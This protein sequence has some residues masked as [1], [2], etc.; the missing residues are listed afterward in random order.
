MIKHTGEDKDNSPFLRP[1]FPCHTVPLQ[2]CSTFAS[3]N[4][5]CLTNS[6]T[7]SSL[8][9]CFCCF[10]VFSSS[11]YLV[12]SCFWGFSLSL[13]LLVLHCWFL[14]LF[15]F[16]LFFFLIFFFLGGGG[17]LGIGSFPSSFFVFVFVL[18][19]SCMQTYDF[20]CFIFSLSSFFSLVVIH[21]SSSLVRLWVCVCVWG[22][23]VPGSLPIR[24]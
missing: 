14:F 19:L 22:G 21:R 18:N 7:V 23:G 13:F 4:T 11:F 10:L 2:M 16:L 6:K 5:L 20:T 8:V 9:F 12:F 1:V 17:G 3:S 24:T 15:P